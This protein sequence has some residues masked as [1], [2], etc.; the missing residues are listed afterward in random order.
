MATLKQHSDTRSNTLFPL[1]ANFRVVRLAE[2]D[3]RTG[4]DELKIFKIWTSDNFS[5]LK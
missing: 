1:A 3:A 2:V 4:S 5:L